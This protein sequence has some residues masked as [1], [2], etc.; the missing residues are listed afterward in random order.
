MMADAERVVLEGLIRR[1]GISQVSHCTLI[2]R[3]GIP[4]AIAIRPSAAHSATIVSSGKG[5]SEDDAARGAIYEAYERWAAEELRV[6]P[7]LDDDAIGDVL[8]VSRGDCGAGTRWVRGTELLT[9]EPCAVPVDHVLFPAVSN[10]PTTTNGLAAGVTFADALNSALFEI[11]E[12]DAIFAAG[13]I[14]RSRRMSIDCP[15]AR[16]FTEADVDIALFR[17]QSPLDVPVVMALARD[18]R[19]PLAHLTCHGFAAAP[20]VWEA[21]QRAMLEVAQ[22]RSGMIM[23]LR[24]DVAGKIAN[25]A[26]AHRLANAYFDMEVSEQLTP[27]PLSAQGGPVGRNGPLD[28]L[29]SADVGPIACIVLDVDW[30]CA[31]RVC[32]PHL[33]GIRGS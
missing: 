26:S 7:S 33:E 24:E 29:R 1:V 28:A 16:V 12:R 11:I 22:S 32:A 25:S 18:R 17:V 8:R 4:V 10:S 14:S 13:L 27:L 20:T 31:V 19:Y 5:T 2:D 21:A 3:L 15:L 23:G 6:A 9:G 30:G